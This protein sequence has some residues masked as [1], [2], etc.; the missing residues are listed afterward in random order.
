MTLI[1]SKRLQQGIFEALA[2][3]N[4]AGGSGG[5]SGIAPVFSL[6]AFAGSTLGGYSTA[7]SSTWTD[8]TGTSFTINVARTSLFFGIGGIT[9]HISAGA[10][11]GYVRATIVG[12][13]ST[14]SP[15]FSLSSATNGTIFYYPTSKGP[16]Q[17]GTYT[18]K[19]QAATDANTTTITI[20]Q[21]SF[22]IFQLGF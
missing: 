1:G 2:S 9:A 13:D 7:N 21:G 19:L 10:Q 3:S 17:P 20:D 16:I 8:V 6:G 12:F 5:G 14:S 22:Q 4:R 15:F 18:V 11:T